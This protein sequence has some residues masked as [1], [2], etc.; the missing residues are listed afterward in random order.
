[1]LRLRQALHQLKERSTQL[2]SRRERELH[3]RLD[4]D[5]TGDPKLGC[6]LDHILEQRG[7]ADTRLAI[8]HQCSAMPGANAV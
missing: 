4:P 3:L 6:S 2:L 7:L 5:G 8:H 1:V